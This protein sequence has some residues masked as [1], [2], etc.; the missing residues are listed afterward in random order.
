MKDVPALS[1]EHAA[2]QCRAFC[3]VALLLQRSGIHEGE[4]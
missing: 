4:T 1:S 2:V 3:S